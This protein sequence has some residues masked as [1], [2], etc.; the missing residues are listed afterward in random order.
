MRIER[1]CYV[2]A[3][4]LFASGLAHLGVQAV[5]GGPWDGPVSWRKPA[6]FGLP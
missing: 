5:L 3:A 1:A 6:D 2:V 4:V